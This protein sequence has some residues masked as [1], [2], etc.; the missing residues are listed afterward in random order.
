MKQKIALLLALVLCLS[1]CAFPVSAADAEFTSGALR[2]VKL[3][4]T[5][6]AVAGLSGAAP[7]GGLEIPSQ[8]TDASGATLTVTEI[9][10]FAFFQ[11]DIAG[12]LKLPDTLV[13]I[14]EYAFTDCTGLTGTLT[15]PASVTEIRESAFDG[16]TGLTGS[17]SLPG[18]LTVIGPLAF[19][20][21]TGLTGTLT[22]PASV[23]VGNFAFD[24]TNLKVS[25][26]TS[27]GWMN[28]G[29]GS[30]EDC[31]GGSSCPSY[32][33]TDV[34]AAHWFHLAVDYVVSNGYMKGIDTT[35]FG[36]DMTLTR[37]MFAQ[38]L[39]NAEGK[40]ASTTSNP[41]T[42]VADGAWYKDAVVWAQPYIGGYG[43]GKFG[44]DDAVT[45]EQLATI[46]YRYA[47]AKDMD[48]TASGSLD[49]FTDGGATSAWAKSA[50]EWAIGQ[51]LL[52]G[53]DGKLN[54]VG[55]AKRSEVATILMRFFTT[56][57][58]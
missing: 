27:G 54:P 41:Y 3:S 34:T 39:Y 56:A 4:D 8:V 49:G 18:S 40:P 33:F 23:T 47:A 20:G 21:C 14:G 31:D 44:P 2:Y 10:K 57:A 38:I 15:I 45:R 43:D 6:A 51:K 55:T 17:L 28:G 50:V 30:S 48:V 52:A 16:C 37:A 26:G 53:S 29:S 9:Q 32:A 11:Q 19:A 13:I 46:L 12:A 1:L 36:P 22:L 5:T 35:A 7:T 24:E 58:A 42:D 25:G